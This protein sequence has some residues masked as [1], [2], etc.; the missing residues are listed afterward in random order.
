MASNWISTLT[1]HQDGKDHALLNRFG[2]LT[3]Q[4]ITRHAKKYIGT[5]TRD[6]QN[7]FMMHQCLAVSLTE[8]A[9]VKVKTLREEYNVNGTN[10]GPL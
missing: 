3:L 6:A 9:K 1:V 5:T 4:S 8:E 7:S 10:D 2:L